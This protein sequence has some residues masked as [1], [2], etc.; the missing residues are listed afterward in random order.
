M[1]NTENTMNFVCIYSIKYENDLISLF[2]ICRT[3][4]V[5]II[6]GVASV[7]FSNDAEELVLNPIERM[8][9]KVRLLAK[10]PLAA[11]SDEIQT[12]GLLSTMD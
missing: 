7:M 10:N 6:L 8:L 11:T 3:L 2:S 12:A 9:E 1:N 5:C 4:F